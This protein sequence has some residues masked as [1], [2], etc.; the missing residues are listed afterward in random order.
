MSFQHTIRYLSHIWCT[1]TVFKGYKAYEKFIYYT[2]FSI[3][4][5]LGSFY[6]FA[7]HS[8][9][10]CEFMSNIWLSD[11]NAVILKKYGFGTYGRANK[12]Q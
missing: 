6:I 10:I 12:I 4:L 5:K 1:V 3:I 9:K 8:L 7:S 2:V 11:I